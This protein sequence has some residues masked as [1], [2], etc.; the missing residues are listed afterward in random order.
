[1]SGQE[2]LEQYKLSIEQDIKEL[3][4]EKNISDILEIEAFTK[5]YKEN[6]VIG[7]RKGKAERDIEI[8][9][10]LLSQNID[11]NTIS[12]DTGLSIADIKKL[13]S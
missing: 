2:V 13:K 10:N 5:K 1:M 12:T 11:I 4:Q 6:F 8:A 7:F 3:L 9:K